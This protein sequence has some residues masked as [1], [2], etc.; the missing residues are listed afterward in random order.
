MSTINFDHV[1]KQYKLYSKGGLYLRDRVTHTLARLNPFK[2]RGV[3]RDR[4]LGSTSGISPASADD[5]RPSAKV[6]GPAPLER[7]FWALKD[8]SFEVNGGESVG[9]IG[10]NGAGKSTILKLLASVTK[11][12]A[13]NVV[14]NGRVAALI[15]VGAG[16]H[17]ELTGRENVFLNGSIL[18]MRKAEIQ[19]SFD[20]IVG[21]SELEKFIDTPVKHYS[22]GM[23][24]RL[25]FAIA[26][27][28]NPDIFLIDE[29]LAVGD[30][31]FQQKCLDTLA[32]HKAAG[33]TIILVSHDLV[34]V[35]EVCDRCVYISQGQIQKDGVPADVIRQYR[36]DVAGTHFNGNSQEHVFGQQ[37][38]ILG[39]TFHGRDGSECAEFDPGDDLIIEVR[40]W[41]HRRIENP[42]FVV[43]IDGRKGAH[44][45]A[46][47][48]R[49]RGIV[50]DSIDGKSSIFCRVPQLSLNEGIY[51]VNV[52]I[53]DAKDG[54]IY[55]RHFGRYKFMVGSGAEHRWGLVKLPAEWAWTPNFGDTSLPANPHA[56]STNEAVTTLLG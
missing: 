49:R 48:T 40:Y 16:F 53:N 17:P 15:E 42:A 4:R 29:V 1:S 18:G 28:T 39:V 23:Y 22:S 46:L 8:V 41:A 25:G 9:F 14:V 26:A 43:D 35:Q 7:D 24:V 36:F 38:E 31:A 37:A 27:H 52:E 21:F 33:K 19:K 12:S 20:S 45:T 34:K 56:R 3:G 30:E 55:D 6:S 47:S 54:Q 11:P 32:A 51:T 5:L 2:Q 44:V 50:I 13:G 10:R